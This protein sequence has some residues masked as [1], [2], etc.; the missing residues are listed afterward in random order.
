MTVGYC[1][2]R[3]ACGKPI[4]KLQNTRFKL[5]EV[6]TDTQIARV[7]V[8]R[9]ITE[10]NN[11]TLTVQEAAMVKWWTTELNKRIVDECL[12]LHG[13]YGYMNEYPIAKA[14]VDNRIQTIYGGTPEIMKQIIGRPLIA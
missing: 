9:C 3:R 5:A 11:K 14:Y 4:S 6:A 12:Q 7:F 2:N 1:T 10:L 13:G 8:D